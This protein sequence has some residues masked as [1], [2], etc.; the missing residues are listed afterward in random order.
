M[1]LCFAIQSHMH[2]DAREPVRPRDIEKFFFVQYPL[3]GISNRTNGFAPML[4]LEESIL[5]LSR[6]KEDWPKHLPMPYGMQRI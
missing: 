2:F 3:A 1:S 5:R 4:T 6:S